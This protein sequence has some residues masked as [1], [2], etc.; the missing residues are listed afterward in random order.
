[1]I[2]IVNQKEGLIAPEE[3]DPKLARRLEI[4]SLQKQIIYVIETIQ[5]TFILELDNYV[6]GH[7]IVPMNRQ[8]DYYFDSSILYNHWY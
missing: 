8:Q 6:E 1:M 3:K 2:F 5:N 4:V 7:H